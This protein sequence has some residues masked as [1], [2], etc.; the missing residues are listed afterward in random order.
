V[1][2]TQSD[3]RVSVVSAWEIALKSQAAKL[4]FG[5]PSERMGRDESGAM[6]AASTGCLLHKLAPKA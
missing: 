3:I 4:S 1:N 6:A 5:I 2:S